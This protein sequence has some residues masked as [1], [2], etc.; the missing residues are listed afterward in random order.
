MIDFKK[1]KVGQKK[2]LTPGRWEQINGVYAEV[3]SFCISKE[4]KKNMQ[5]QFNLKTTGDR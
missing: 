3:Q 5:F 1:M 4:N 2:E